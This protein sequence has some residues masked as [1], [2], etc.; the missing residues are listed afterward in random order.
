[1]NDN[2]KI[3]EALKSALESFAPAPPP[4]VKR[5][6]LTTIIATIGFSGGSTLFAATTLIITG[7]V[8]AGITAAVFIMDKPKIEQSNT[9][10]P[11][12]TAHILT[13][14]ISHLADD[15]GEAN[16]IG[17]TENYSTTKSGSTGQMESGIDAQVVD[18]AADKSSRNSALSTISEADKRTETE[19]QKTQLFA[20]KSSNSVGSDGTSSTYATSN[21]WSKAGPQAFRLVEGIKPIKATSRTLSH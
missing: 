15:Q 2:H 17:E 20:T 12:D 4:R 3:E 6:I 9:H 5:R 11:T 13:Q 14:S 18:H 10:K 19:N 1:M 21:S 16:R 8:V 7:T